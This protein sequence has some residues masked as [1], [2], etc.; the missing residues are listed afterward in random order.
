MSTTS[1]QDWG[2]AN[3]WA[4]ESNF[5]VGPQV[6]QVC[7]AVHVCT[8][9]PWCLRVNVLEPAMH[10]W[11]CVCL[12]PLLTPGWVCVQRPHFLLYT[13]DDLQCLVRQTPC[14]G[15]LDYLAWGVAAFRSLYMFSIDVLSPGF[16]VCGCIDV[17]THG[18][19]GLTVGFFLNAPPMRG[20][21]TVQWLSKN[22]ILVW[23]S[24]STLKYMKRSVSLS[25]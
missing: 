15:L 22:G 16:L 19:R 9:V 2:L 14:K 20:C 13:C 11:F 24:N 7:I 6:L 4:C 17:R 10:G 8:L 18:Y 3:T 25:V 23:A 12:H 5:P 1:T 21:Q